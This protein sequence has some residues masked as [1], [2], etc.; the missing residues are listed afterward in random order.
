M[1]LDNGN[2]LNVF[3]KDSEGNIY[4]RQT[5]GKYQSLTGNTTGGKSVKN[6]MIIGVTGSVGVRTIECSTTV[7]G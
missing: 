2:V 6:K 4:Q 7:T 5:N 3:Y 1:K